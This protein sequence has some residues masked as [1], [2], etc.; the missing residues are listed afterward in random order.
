[1]FVPNLAR[2][3]LYELANLY[4][5]STARFCVLVYRLIMAASTAIQL[6]HV[7]DNDTVLIGLRRSMLH[8]MNPVFIRMRTTAQQY[9][10]LALEGDAV[11]AFCIELEGCQLHVVEEMR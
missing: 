4:C 7:S 11:L 5:A 8:N 9:A 2:R 1:M 10:E 3:I 6:L